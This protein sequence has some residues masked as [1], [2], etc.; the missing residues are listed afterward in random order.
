MLLEKFEDCL[1]LVEM[2]KQN[3]EVVAEALCAHG[4]RRWQKRNLDRVYFS[5][6]ALGFSKKCYQGS[7]SHL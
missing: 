5:A 2:V 7:L 1:N 3:K 4:G 6:E